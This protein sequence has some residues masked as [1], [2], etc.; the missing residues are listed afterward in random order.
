MHLF[1][2]Q[3][4]RPRRAV[5][6]LLAGA[7][8]VVGSGFA[9][10]EARAAARAPQA[11]TCSR[12]RA[13]YA[14]PIQ[15]CGR[16]EGVRVAQVALRDAGYD[17]AADNYFGPRTY[18]ALR[19]FQATHQLPVTGEIDERS[20]VAL[21]GGHGAGYDADG[22][23]IV[24]PWELGAVPL[25]PQAPPTC[26]QYTAVDSGYPIRRCEKGWFVYSTQNMLAQLGYDVA[27]DGYFGP[28]TERAVRAFQAG[29]GLAV[30]GLVGPRTWSALSSQFPSL[31]RDED[32]NGIADPW[33]Y[34][35]DCFLAERQW[36]CAGE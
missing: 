14:Y 18:A 2:N 32:G 23:G 6:A 26:A 21:T 19:Q 34:P 10:T 13:D 33:E 24:D 22:D 35:A 8:A 11:V 28:Q 27:G 9:A 4:L 29:A 1:L 16:G 15:L 20:W 3:R 25:P 31:G 17:I 30:D 7:S 36:E 12:Y 5:L